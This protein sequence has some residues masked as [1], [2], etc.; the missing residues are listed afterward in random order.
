MFISTMDKVKS[1]L[2]N[3]VEYVDH[4][5]LPSK[6]IRGRHKSKIKIIFKDASGNL[7]FTLISSTLGNTKR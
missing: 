7:K 5:E 1:F 4:I 6:V 2:P 3:N